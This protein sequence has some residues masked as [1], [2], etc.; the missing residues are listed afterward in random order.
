MKEFVARIL[1]IAASLALA[2]WLLALAWGHVRPL[3]PIII[4]AGTVVVALQILQRRRD[5]W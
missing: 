4:A 1:E 3:V 2:A 5:G